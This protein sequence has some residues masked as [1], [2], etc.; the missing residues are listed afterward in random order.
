M[1]LLLTIAP[2]SVL[3]VSGCFPYHF[4]TRAGVSGVVVDSRSAMPVSDATIILSDRPGRSPA[5]AHTDVNGDFI[6]APGKAWAIYMIPM[7]VF[8]GRTDAAISAPGYEGVSLTVKYDPWSRRA[9]SLGKIQLQ[10]QNSQ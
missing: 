6:M 7:D 5:T 2:V 8:P 10:P 3:A 9:V 4:T 1:R